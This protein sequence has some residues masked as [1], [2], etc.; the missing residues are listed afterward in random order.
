MHLATRDYITTQI[1]NCVLTDIKISCLHIYIFFLSP[2]SVKYSQFGFTLAYLWWLS[3]LRALLLI[4]LHCITQEGYENDRCVN[5]RRSI[6]NCSLFTFKQ[7]VWFKK[8]ILQPNVM[9]IFNNKECANSCFIYDTWDTWQDTGSSF[10]SYASSNEGSA[11]AGSPNT[12][13]P[14]G[15]NQERRVAILTVLKRSRSKVW[16]TGEEG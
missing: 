3:M 5:Q 8:K 2:T 14:C 15:R 11:G 7:W 9:C 16:E 13:G 12:T 1:S 10:T 6:I 4:E